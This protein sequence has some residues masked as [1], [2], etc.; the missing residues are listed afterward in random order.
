MKTLKG[1]VYGLL[2]VSV[3][4]L[5]TGVGAPIL[6]SLL[7]GEKEYREP[8]PSIMKLPPYTNLTIWGYDSV[9]GKDWMTCIVAG[10]TTK[11]LIIEGWG[12]L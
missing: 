2:V 7:K 4:F 9:S 11:P 6:I 1:I 10:D 3:F 5:I 12:E 8:T